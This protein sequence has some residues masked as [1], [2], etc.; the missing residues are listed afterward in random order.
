[1]SDWLEMV[2]Q[3]LIEDYDLPKS[4]FDYMDERM[5]E[6]VSVKLSECMGDLLE[7]LEERKID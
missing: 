6:I 4:L 1:V 5:N 7:Q 2:K 3:E